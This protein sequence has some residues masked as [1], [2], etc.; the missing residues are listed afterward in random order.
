MKKEVITQISLLA[1][2]SVADVTMERPTAIVN[3]HVRLEVSG[4][5]ERFV[6]C[7]ALVRLLL[8]R[9]VGV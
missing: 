1:E 2:S 8:H 3:V 7:R 6:A 4:S 5:R 9:H